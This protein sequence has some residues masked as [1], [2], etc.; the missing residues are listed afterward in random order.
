[1]KSVTQM[2][3]IGLTAISMSLM[4]GSA[5]ANMNST[6]NAQ[7]DQNQPNA[8]SINKDWQQTKEKFDIGRKYH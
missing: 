5:L 4:S 3:M 8:T 1:M 2:T 6:D 7:L